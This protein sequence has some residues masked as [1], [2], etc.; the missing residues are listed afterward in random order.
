[1]PWL[2]QAELSRTRSVEN[3]AGSKVGHAPGFEFHVHV[4]HIRLAGENGQTYRADF[5]T[6]D[7]TIE[8]TMSRS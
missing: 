7:F 6:G 8:S 4:G 3:P 2:K 5:L 1:M